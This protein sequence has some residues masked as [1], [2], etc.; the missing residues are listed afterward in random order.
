MAKVTATTGNIK[1]KTIIQGESHTFLAD[2]P[3]D[4]GGQNSGPTPAEMLA[5]AL[6]S[7]TTITVQMYASRKEWPLEEVIVDVEVDY[8]S[9][10]GTTLFK[11]EIEF[12]GALTEEQRT[13]LYVIAGK[14]PINKALQQKIVVE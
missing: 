11:K 7:C 9:E 13:R 3:V 10:P 2:E 4:L 12:R 5:A 1:Y 8:T 6:A 14:C